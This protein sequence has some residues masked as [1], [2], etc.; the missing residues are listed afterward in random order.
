MSLE[1]PMA[2]RQEAQHGPSDVPA[3]YK[4]KQHKVM[5]ADDLARELRRLQPPHRQTYSLSTLVYEALWAV[6]MVEKVGVDGHAT[7]GKTDG[8]RYAV[9][10]APPEQCEEGEEVFTSIEKKKE[11]KKQSCG[12]PSRLKP[13]YTEEFE[14][15]WAVFTSSPL[16]ANQSKKAAFT[17]HWEDACADVGAERLLEAAQAAVNEQAQRVQEGGE[18]LMLPDCFRW[19]REER[20]QH[21]LNKPATITIQPKLTS[22]SQ[23]DWRQKQEEDARALAATKA[24]YGISD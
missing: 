5:V 22:D 18:P 3:H 17:K 8:N 4:Q 14:R 1:C 12:K 23:K 2:V 9:V 15:F 11:D 6:V 20:Y 13:K 10:P 24:R 16:L 21:Y 7:L 19:L